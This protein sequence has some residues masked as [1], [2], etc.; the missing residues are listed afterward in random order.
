MKDPITALADDKLLL[1]AADVQVQLERGTANRP[2]L[3]LLVRAR[4]KAAE[5]L[6]KLV[7][8][9]ASEESAIRALQNEVRLYGDMVEHCR[10]LMEVGRSEMARIKES[11]RETMAELVQDLDEETQRLIGVQPASID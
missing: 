4:E 3:W 2:V 9:D 5:A 6:T 8:V 10:N 7:E 1:L 11:D